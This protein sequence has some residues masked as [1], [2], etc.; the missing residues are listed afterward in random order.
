MSC[1]ALNSCYFLLHRIFFYSEDVEEAGSSKCHYASDKLHNVIFQKRGILV[2]PLEPQTSLI[3]SS[4][5]SHIKRH[6]LILDF[7]FFF[8]SCLFKLMFR[9][10]HINLLLISNTSMAAVRI[11]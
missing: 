1:K 3:Y 2:M 6:P 4:V 8:I 7:F 11:Y 10:R 9:F 5:N